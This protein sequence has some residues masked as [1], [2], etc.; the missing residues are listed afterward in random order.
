MPLALIL[1]LLIAYILNNFSEGHCNFHFFNVYIFLMSKHLF[2]SFS[3]LSVVLRFFVNHQQ[4][5]KNPIFQMN[6]VIYYL[7]KGSKVLKAAYKPVNL[8]QFSKEPSHKDSG[9]PSCSQGFA[10]RARVLDLF[11]VDK[12]YQNDIRISFFHRSRQLSF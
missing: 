5:T 12:V 4:M 6:F 7:S 10:N 11:P 8:L 3:G 2:H 9:Y 1:S